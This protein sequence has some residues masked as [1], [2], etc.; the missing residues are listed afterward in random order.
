[1]NV[2]LIL[3]GAYF[4]SIGGI[5]FG[6]RLIAPLELVLALI[7]IR[8]WLQGE[9]GGFEGF[10]QQMTSG[11][12]FLVTLFVYLAN[13]KTIGAVDTLPAKYLPFSL[14]REAN[15]DFDE[16]SFLYLNGIPGYLTLS[17]DH[18]VSFFPPFAGV[19]ALPIYA[20]SALA[21]VSPSSRLVGDLEKVSAS[22]ITALSVAILFLT[23]RRLADKNDAL[24]I[25]T[26]YAFGSSTFSISAQALW[27]HGP[28]ELFLT[29]SLYCLVRGLQERRFSAYAGFALAAAVV[30]RPTNI[31]IALP[32]AI[33]VL[34]CQ[35]DQVARFLFLALAPALFLAGYNYYYWG[36]AL[37]MPYANL[38]TDQGHW[39]PLL[40]GFAARLFSPNRGLLI[41]SPV[42]LFSVVGIYQ[43]SRGKEP[44]LFRYCAAG[45]VLNILWYSK[46]PAWQ[47]WWS[48]PPRY[49]TDLSPL[50]ALFLVPAWRSARSRPFMR[51]LF[52]T[53]AILSIAIHSMGVFLP[54]RWRP[55][56]G[57][58]VKRM[59]D[60]SDGQ[61]VHLTGQLLYKVT[62]RFRPLDYPMGGLSIDTI[63]CRPGEHITVTV[64]LIPGSYRQPIDVYL[65]VSR[66]DGQSLFLTQQSLEMLP[67]PFLKSQLISERQRFTV[68]YPCKEDLPSGTYNAGVY[69]VRAGGPADFSPLAEDII[70]VGGGVSFHLLRP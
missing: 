53:C 65:V 25:A 19:I 26:V 14:L 36:S 66:P 58:D 44:R 32:L 6:H 63:N 62:G 70:H 10:L 60:W 24:L 8:T 2:V 43:M 61:L 41:Y 59:W 40:E 30:C 49:L 54:N 11:R 50:L 64:D 42:F 28:S 9:K 39:M 34:H 45:V 18:Y 27:Q 22:V 23:L 16:F 4:F 69:S 7:L 33:Y 67:E 20:V 13:G 47:E 68:D 3:L 12:L 21:G 15:F 1:V 48:F 17:R 38:A 37:T 5:R 46:W 57:S 51:G 55:D 56:L 29:L 35:R 52:L 31:L